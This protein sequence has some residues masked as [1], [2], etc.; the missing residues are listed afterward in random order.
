MGDFFVCDLFDAAPK[1][2]MAS[3]EHPIFSLST[4]PDRRV[5]LYE[6]NGTFVKI[7]PSEAG[8]ATVHDRDVLIFCISQVMAALN[9]DRPV[10]KVL[11][12]KA[13]DLL[14]ATN[15]GI[16]GRGYEQL[17]ASFRRLQ[18]TQI[19]TNITTGGVE[20]F[21]LFSLI[22]RARITRKSRD[23]RMIDVEIHLSDWVF[24]AIQSNEVLT[25][26]RDYF[27]LRK[28][29]ERRVYELARKHCGRQH[30][31]K[32]S[33]ETLQKKCGSNSTLREFR[34]L[35]SEI[36]EQDQAHAH[37][38]DYALSFVDDLLTVQ[39]RRVM[40][41]GSMS[42]LSY[43]RV[44]ISEDGYAAARRAAPGWDVYGL[45]NQWKEWMHKG[46]KSPPR[47]PDAAFA[48]WCSRYFDNHGKP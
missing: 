17:K 10:S 20:A 38:P 26:H 19:E 13:H 30:E 44:R 32:I 43:E 11:R 47:V 4:K 15:R 16:D 48:K 40:P 42:A 35:L 36:V 25:I 46:Q 37:M 1:G 23:G 45:E 3:M 14:I 8:L 22:D 12:F 21:D 29:L 24:N 9:D 41:E 7:S 39:P 5:R 18:G 28:P 6:H 31:W 33:L 2:D 34:R 27:R